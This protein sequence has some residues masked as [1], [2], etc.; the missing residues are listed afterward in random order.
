MLCMA[1]LVGAT[2]PTVHAKRPAPKP[3]KPSVFNGVRY[4]A[5]NDRGRVCYVQAWDVATGA[6]NW[7]RIIYE[8]RIDPKIEEDV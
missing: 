5:P 7:E 4:T 3:V 8:A 6:L 2:A 1:V